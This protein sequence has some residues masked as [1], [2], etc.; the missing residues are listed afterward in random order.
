MQGDQTGDNSGGD[1]KRP[2]PQ[3]RAFHE[4]T[5]AF[6]GPGERPKGRDDLVNR[7]AGSY[8]DLPDHM[9]EAIGGLSDDQVAEIGKLAGRLQDMGMTFELPGG[10]VCLL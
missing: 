5:A 8:D 2:D 4:L 10:R 1:E 6:T 3:H 7:L 9:R